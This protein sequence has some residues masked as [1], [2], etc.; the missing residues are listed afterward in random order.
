MGEQL[1]VFGG[2]FDPLHVGHLACAEAARVALQLDRVVLVVA[3]DPWQKHGEVVASARDRLD[4]AAAAVEGLDG[5]EVSAIEIDRPGPT[6]TVDTLAALRTPGR[7]L[8]LV[9]GADVAAA[10]ETW[11]R[12]EDLPALASLVVVD[13]AGEPVQD[14][15]AWSGTMTRVPMDAV[16]VSSTDL[17]ERI[18]AGRSVEGL[19]PPAAVR[20][21]VERGLYTAAR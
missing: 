5:I 14:G 9:V 21:I 20:L 10:I 8:F 6:F 1:G 19:I 12:A 16:D 13:R 3:G 11:H 18:R 7:E 4:M 15:P 17:R 2:T